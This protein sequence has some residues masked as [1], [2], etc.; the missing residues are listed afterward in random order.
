MNCPVMDN[1][2]DPSKQ[3]PDMDAELSTDKRLPIS[4]D[5]T[6][7]NGDLSP[8]TEPLNPPP[9]GDLEQAPRD[10]SLPPDGRMSVS[11]PGVAETPDGGW[12][13]VIVG[14]CMVYFILA[15]GMSNSFG[16]YFIALQ[17]KFGGTAAETA[18]V[19]ALYNTMRM[20]AGKIHCLHN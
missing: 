4:D 1:S 2:R 14:G 18:W 11:P 10:T 6:I 17:E 3:E 5:V 15:Q 8:E 12:G 13:W 20:V 7:A 19:N 16:V 9:S